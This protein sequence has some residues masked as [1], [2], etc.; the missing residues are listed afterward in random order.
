MKCS[1]CGTLLS[2]H[3]G[4]LSCPFCDKTISLVP[5][6]RWCDKHQSSVDTTIFHLW[7]SI[8]FACPHQSLCEAYNIGKEVC[9]EQTQ[10]EIPFT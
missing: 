8:C 1:D 10:E 6:K 9:D 5:P 3:Q 7:E 2:H 4:V